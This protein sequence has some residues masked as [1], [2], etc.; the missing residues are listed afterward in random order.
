MRALLLLDPDRQAAQRAF[1]DE[2]ATVLAATGAGLWVDM[3]PALADGLAE[4][5]IHVQPQDGSGRIVL[6]AVVFNP[7]ERLP[8]LPSGLDAP[9]TRYQIVQCIAPPDEAWLQALQEL[10][11]VYLGDVQAHAALFSL[12]AEQQ[13][14]ASSLPGVAWLGPYHPAYALSFELAGQQ[15]PF[16]ADGLAQARPDPALFP[17][18]PEGCLRV[19]LFADIPPEA[20]RAA[21][22]AAGAEVLGS[23]GDA[24]HVNPPP[25]GVAA[26]LR[27]EGVRAVEPLRQ[28]GFDNQRAGVI[29]GANQVRNFGNVDFVV[30]LDGSGEIVGVVDS[31]LDNGAIPTTH[32]DFHVAGA[33][34]A[35]RV[36]RLDNLNP[37]AAGNAQDVVGH[38]THVAGS[39]VGDG[40]NAPPPIPASPTNSVPRGMA[41]AA[42]LVLTS[43]NNFPLPAPPGLPLNFSR[44]LTAFQNH[45]AAGARV[46]TNSWGARGPNQYTNETGTYDRYTWLHPDTVLLFSAGNAEADLNN[47]G[48]LDQNTLG[49]EATAKNT[50][51]IG[52]SENVTTLEGEARN[53]QTR[54]GP[55]NRYGT[56]GASPVRIAAN[57]AAPFSGSDNAQ[58]LAMFSCRGRVRNPLRPTHR[59]AKP[60]LVAPGTNILSTRSSAMAV[61]ATI[62]Q[63]CPPIANPPGIPNPGIAVTAPPALYRLTSGTSMATPLAA[64]ACLL[65]RQFYRQ[66]YGQLRRP[67]LVEALPQLVDLPSAAT[68]PGRRMVAWVRR[69]VGAGHNH[70][71]AVALD[72]TPLAAGA[73]TVLASNVGDSPAPALALHGANTLLLWRDAAGALQLAA[74]DAAL[75]PLA[76]F[77]TA[78]VVQVAT[79]VRTD[80]ANPPSLCVLGDAVA[81]AWVRASDSAVLLRRHAAATG[82]ALDATDRKLGVASATSAHPWLQHDGVGWAAVWQ[83]VTAGQQRLMWRAVG[84]DGKA[85]GTQPLRLHGQAEVLGAP[86][87]AWDDSRA[88]W[89]LAWVSEAPASRGIHTRR[90]DRAGTTLGLAPT[91]VVPLAA[92]VALRQ[93]RLQPHTDGGHVLLWEDA[94]QGTFDVWLSLLNRDGEA[95]AVHRVQVSDTPQPTAGFS[96]VVDA[97]GLVPLWLGN[98]EANSDQQGLFLVGLQ[99]NG[100]FAAQQDA[101]TPLLDQQFYVP[102]TLATQPELDRVANALV[103][104]GGDVLLLRGRGQLFM[105]DLELVRTSA[106]GVPDAALGPGGARRIDRGFGFEAVSLAWSGALVA[107]GSSHG[108]ENTLYLLQPDGTP[109]AGFGT[110][111][112]LSLNEPS[113]APVHLQVAVQGRGNA[114]R[115]FAAYGLFDAAGRHTLRYTVRGRNGQVLLATR[116]LARAEGTAKQGWFHW[117][118]S[119]TP[120]HSIAAWHVTVGVALQVQVQRFRLNGTAQL[121][122]PN[123][124]P[125]TAAAGD[126][127]NAVLAP[128]PVQF[129][130]GFPVSAADLLDTRRREFGAAWQHRTAAAGNWQIWFSRLTRT[131][132]PVATAGQFDVVVVNVATEHATDPQLVWHGDGYGLAWLQQPVAG[133]NHLLMFT[134]LDPLG[135]RPDLAASGPVALATDFQVSAAGGDVQRFHLIWAGASFRIAWTEVQAGV[136]HHRQRGIALP[137]PASGARYDAPFQQPSAALVKATLINGAT[138]L[139]NTSLPNQGND[140]N[141]G[142]GWGRIN[143]RQAL[144]PAQPVSFQVRDDACVGAGGTVRYRLRLQPGTQLLRITLAWTDPPGADLVNHLHLRVTTPAFAVG[145]VQVLHGNRWHTTAGQQHLSRPVTGTAPPFEDTHTVQQVVLAAPPALPAGD[146]LVEVVCSALG[147]SAFQQFPG[148]AFALVFVGSG[149]EL[150]TAANPAAAPVGIY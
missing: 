121:G 88:C 22:Q 4:A 116:D 147:G 91:L 95:T 129:A 136:L 146:Y 55:C 3:N 70:I 128:R 19:V 103:W 73:A 141:D 6:P 117:L 101:A 139:R 140:V 53:Y 118:A 29:L 66:R 107:A 48:V 127:M 137:R 112:V 106:D 59:R 115:L 114:L 142:Y 40:R 45:Y 39:I 143:L 90:L 62:G 57:V 97:S 124:V 16:D 109:A 132:V 100:V 68:G 49:P 52:A 17:P 87:A 119:E 2:R 77:G 37:V 74:F 125:L 35:S 1:V 108:P 25:A 123:P 61:P 145:G 76:G 18:Q 148:Q 75:Q 47:S 99:K 138:N 81:V 98:D 46:Q 65:V 28:P 30:N 113:A 12:S 15:E 130:P 78:G 56:L 96:A 135:Q 44:A 9:R 24:L 126:A 72:N 5:G 134:V 54:T 85:A 67:A 42:R 120:Q 93:P 64:G 33:A 69:D 89:L 31:G 92:P 131:G 104:A 83:Q 43:V 21:L 144:A 80:A 27:V 41:P 23:D 63:A 82:R 50:L 20:G 105:T 133:G 102:Q 11:G 60:D 34:A 32:S 51:V 86:H 84:A 94:S 111:G 110:Q 7:A 13:E 150:R 26:L 71:V 10:G 8:Q 38:G 58:D 149:A 79:G 14:A 122:Q 36:I